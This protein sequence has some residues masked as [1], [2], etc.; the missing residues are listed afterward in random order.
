MA[1]N[2]LVATP[3]PAFGELLRLSLEEC[4]RYRVRLV[5]TGRDA[6]AVSTDQQFALAILDVALQDPPVSIVAQGLRQPQPALHVLLIPSGN[7]QVIPPDLKFDGTISQ[8]FYAPE[9]L[10]RVD[11]LTGVP[12]SSQPPRHP[13]RL[14]TELLNQPSPVYMDPHLAAYQ[15]QETLQEA[16]AAGALILVSRQPWASAGQFST[17]ILE[18]IASILARYTDSDEGVD[19]ARYVHL[20]SDGS[21]HLI[22][23][24]PLTTGIVLAL[25]CPVTTKLTAIRAQ[26]GRLARLL[27]QPAEAPAPRP[28]PPPKPVAAAAPPAPVAAPAPAAPPTPEAVPAPVEMSA[29]S[30]PAAPA[31]QPTAEPLQPDAEALQQAEVDEQLS[32]GHI[33]R[34]VNLLSEMP[35][36]N[37]PPAAQPTP[38]NGNGEHPA[39]P[40]KTE[41]FLFPWEQPASAAQPVQAPLPEQESHPLQTP[42]PPPADQPAAEPQPE[43]QVTQPAVPAAEESTQ[44]TALAVNDAG[45]VVESAPAGPS[46]DADLPPAPLPAPA[47]APAAH[48]AAQAS[49]EETQPVVLRSLSSIQQVEPIASPL[50]NL[51]YTCLLI[52]R[53]PSHQLGSPLADS[54]VEWIPQLCQAYG[55]RMLDLRVRPD[56]LQW[57]V[58]AAPAISPGNVVRLIRQQA[59]RRVFQQFPQLEIDNPSGDFWAPGYL[60]IS[61]FQP[62]SIQLVHDFIRQTRQRQGMAPPAAGPG[63]QDS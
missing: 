47:P 13:H 60:I 2:I 53:M 40:Q 15:L 25:V 48:P 30:Q 51:T 11:A 9:L 3:Q 43:A 59:S 31:N 37:P 1:K 39:D 56:Y 33:L 14:V 16:V 35:T 52:P 24:T 34:L 5:P 23:A 22:Y 20:Q 32:A 61:G 28:E 58:Q 45:E 21:E 49:S 26:A 27:R 57:T 38:P 36:P 62:P 42:P 17:A 6:L 18:E 44:P 10:T 4:G 12:C 63:P 41:T 54:L 50:S 29:A 7:G 8:P 46:P 55:W 19:L